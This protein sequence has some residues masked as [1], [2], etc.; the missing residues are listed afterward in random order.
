MAFSV[1]K[2]FSLAQ[3]TKAAGYSAPARRHCDL[4]EWSRFRMSRLNGAR[5]ETIFQVPANRRAGRHAGCLPS[6][7]ARSSSYAN[8]CGVGGPNCQTMEIIMGGPDLFAERNF[9]TIHPSV[10]P[11]IEAVGQASE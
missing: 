11:T 4:R 5:S 6:S 8:G 7:A 2:L 1:L 3:K 9:P 10:R